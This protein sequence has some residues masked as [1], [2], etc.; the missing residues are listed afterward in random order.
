MYKNM[1]QK[2]DDVRRGGSINVQRPFHIPC[3]FCKTINYILNSFAFRN[4]NKWKRDMV[5]KRRAIVLLF[6]GITTTV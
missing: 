2:L 6:Q 1:K 5:S 3:L 4:N